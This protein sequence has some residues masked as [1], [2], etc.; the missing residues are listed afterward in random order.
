[1]SIK[2]YELCTSD[3][4]TLDVFVYCSNGMFHDEDCYSNSPS[5]EHIQQTAASPYAA[6]LVNGH[7]LYTDIYYTSPTS[8]DFFI[9]NR[10]HICGIVQVNRK[11]YAC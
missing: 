4:I 11:N 5:T 9:N 8:A 7:I 3:G 6:Y 1:M 2:L 10:T